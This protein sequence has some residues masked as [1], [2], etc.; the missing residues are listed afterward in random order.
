[1]QKHQSIVLAHRNYY[2]SIK[3]KI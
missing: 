3:H 1:M 2:Q